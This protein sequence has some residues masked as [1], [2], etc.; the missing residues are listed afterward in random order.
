M[1]FS[2]ADSFVFYFVTCPEICATWRWNLFLKVSH[3]FKRET[4]IEKSLYMDYFFGI[5]SLLGTI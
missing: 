3:Y 4:F 1:L 5:K 2:H